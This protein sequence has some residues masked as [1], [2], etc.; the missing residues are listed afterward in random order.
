M[1]MYSSRP[2]PLTLATYGDLVDEVE[3]QAPHNCQTMDRPAVWA[4]LHAPEAR[5]AGRLMN[6]TTAAQAAAM[7]H[8][9]VRAASCSRNHL[10]AML[11][12]ESYVLQNGG[13]WVPQLDDNLQWKALCASVRSGD[14]G[15]RGL[16]QW[17]QR[18]ITPQNFTIARED[19]V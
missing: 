3:R 11:C 5:A 4:A 9:L 8:R 17:I 18:R 12:V 15:R 2:H 14:L 6:R 10:V 16:S 13:L 19:T 1:P 7:A